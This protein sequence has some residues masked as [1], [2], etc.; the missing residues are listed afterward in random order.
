VTGLA[1]K[2][3]WARKVRALTTTFALYFTH[4]VGLRAT[5]VGLALSVA[6]LVGLLVHPLDE[7]AQAPPA[8]VVPGPHLIEEEADAPPV[9]A[10]PAPVDGELEQAALAHHRL[11]DL[12]H[13]APP[14]LLPQ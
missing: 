12:A 9:V 4:V 8:G 14:T 1:L 13:A 11:D 6:A 3:L 10:R 2:S 7:A 5:Q